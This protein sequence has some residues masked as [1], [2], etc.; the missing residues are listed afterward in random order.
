MFYGADGEAASAMAVRL[1]VAVTDRDWF[2]HLRQL[3][4]PAEVNFWSPSPRS[5]QALREGELFLFKLHAPFNVIVGGGVFALANNMPLALAWEAF[6]EANGARDL[7]EMRVRILRYRYI[8]D[9]KA[10]IDIGCRILTQ[11]FF[12]PESQWFSP[13]ASWSRNIVSFRTYST[14]EAE[15]LALWEKIL[16][17]HD[18]TSLMPTDGLQEPRFG[19]PTLI[20]PRL[21]QGAFRLLVT[22]LYDR[23]CAIT[24]ER[25]LPAL[26]AAHVRPYA[27]G[28]EHRASNGVLFRR[29]I[30]SLFDAGYVT[31]NR[32]Y[33]FEVSRRIKEEFENGR[34][35]YALNE[36]NLTV[37]KHSDLRPDL[38]ALD[39]HN[40]NR[41]LG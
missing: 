41:F 26:E 24:G 31:V 16:D 13:P 15:G 2:D 7:N 23:R 36:K 21:G 17:L 32:D 6:G 34:D 8:E 1:V 35:Y 22:D 10:S 18:P 29:D 33:R 19:E 37:P 3:P 11:P 9:Q 20:R 25:T 12:L 4:N 30:H 39:W 40:Q 38:I 28:G 5:F 27:N 14:D